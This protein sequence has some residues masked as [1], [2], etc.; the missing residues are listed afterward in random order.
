MAFWWKKSPK[1]PSDYVKHLNEQLDKLE[2]ASAGSDLRKKAQDECGKYIAGTKHFLLKET[3]PVPTQEALDELY[4][5]IYQSDLFFTL[6]HSFP[7]LDFEARKD[8]A[9][10]YCICLSRSK[11]NKFPTVDYL[12]TKPKFVSMLLKTSEVCIT[13]PGGSDIFLTASGMILETIKQE[14][15]CR[16]I[17]RDQQIW[18]F[19][20]FTRLGS[21]EISSSSLQVLTELFTTHPKLVSVEFFSNE[22]N[23]NQFIDRIN[24]L[25]AHGNYVTKRQSVKLLGTLIFNRVNKNLMTTYIN[26]SDNVKLVM[27]LLSDRSKNLQLESFNI[28]KVVVANPRKSKPVLDVLVKN[29]DKLLNFLEQFGTDNKDSTFLDEKEFIVEQIEALP[30]I[31]PASGE[32]TLGTSPQK[33]MLL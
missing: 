13:R 2:S 16:L 7:N 6:L 31:V 14:Q 5:W 20:D 30:R 18:K 8:V 9:M 4:Y 21:F 29:R 22:D 33:N 12:L 23:M 3:D 27:I 19:F 28:F 25:M 24:K 1:T 11:D 26:N 15:L 32:Y 10:I 17:I